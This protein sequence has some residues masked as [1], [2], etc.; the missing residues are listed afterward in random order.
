MGMAETEKKE[1]KE[2]K[3]VKEVKEVKGVKETSGAARNFFSTS[4]T[5]GKSRS[6]T[7]PLSGISISIP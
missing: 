4:G 7:P 3:E 2:I 1:Q 5:W 6:M